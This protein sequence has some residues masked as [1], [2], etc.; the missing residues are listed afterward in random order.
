[1]AHSPGR[2]AAPFRLPGA[3]SYNP[4][5]RCLSSS[6]VETGQGVQ[7]MVCVIMGRGR[8]S[9]PGEEWTAAAESGAEL[10]EIRADCLRREPDMKRILRDRPTPLLFTL[11]RGVDGGLWRGPEEKRMGLLREAIALGVDYVD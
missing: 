5:R 4:V 10:V 1:M 11:R 9:S 8:H 6:E 3:L 2:F 7:A